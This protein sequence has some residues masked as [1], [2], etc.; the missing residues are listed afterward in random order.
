VVDSVSELQWLVFAETCRRGDE[1]GNAKN[2]IEDFGYG[3]GYVYSLRIW[4]ELIDAVNAL[5]NHKAMSV[6]LIA[7]S[8]ITRFDDPETVS[9]DLGLSP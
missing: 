3:K 9:Y 6:V 2:N 5:R 8:T 1:K 4:Q 7:H